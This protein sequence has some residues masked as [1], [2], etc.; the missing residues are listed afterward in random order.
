MK[1]H[2]KGHLT[3][4]LQRLLSAHRRL[5]EATIASARKAAEEHAAA[6][7]AQAGSD[8]AKSEKYGK[9]AQK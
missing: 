9:G 6:R 1:H 3:E 7:E 4:K 2:P 5:H 8:A